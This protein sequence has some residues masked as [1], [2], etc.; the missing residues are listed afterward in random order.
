MK[1]FTVG[2]VACYPEVLEEMRRQMF[3]HRSKEYKELHMEV[4]ERM[5]KFLET[6]NQIFLFP[7]SGTGFMEGSV[8]N[9]VEKKMLCCVNGE[10]GR[11]YVEVG[12]SNGKVVEKLE[13]K[14]G[15]PITP[16]LLDEKLSS[17]PDVEAVTITHNETSTG[18]L[19]PLP[20][21]AE[22]VKKHGKLLFVDAVSSMGGVDIKVDKW[23]IDVCFGSSQK[24]FGLP[25][26]LAIGS[27][28]EEALK[29]SERIKDKGWYFDF[30][31][32]EKYQKE[33]FSTPMTPA[34]PQILALR[35]ILEMIEENGG[36]QKQFELYLE[37][38]RRIREGVM[39]LGFT[40]FPEKGYESPT[41][42]CVNATGNLNGSEIYE[43]MRKK[44]FELARGYGAI[45]DV[46]FRIG[47]MGYITF[48]DIDLMLKALEEVV[49][50]K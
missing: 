17:C 34:I 47:N 48:E 9:C 43:R 28:S 39:K 37:R 20:E 12:V 24:C 33:Q 14:L 46:T 38:S 6:E 22:V 18:L 31:L 29:K 25:P 1:L 27:V 23:G 21:L 45:R 36:K 49:A 2:P 15:K 3:S 8:R 44:G 32:F 19:N 7:S 40:L 4:V 35:K 50:G 30:K 26:G 11:R 10:F 5:R 41:V 42:T 13:V 16:D